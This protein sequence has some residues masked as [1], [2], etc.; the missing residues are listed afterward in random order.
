[1]SLKVI[2]EKLYPSYSKK[3]WKYI[4]EES[5][6]LFVQ[7]L[8]ICSLQYKPEDKSELINK[9]NKD[10][11]NIEDLFKQLVSTKEIDA[12]MEKLDSLIGG[13]VDSL[14]NTAVHIVK[15]KVSMG[16]QFNENCIVASADQKC[17]LRLRQDFS[18]EQK[19]AV[20]DAIN[21][22]SEIIKLAERKEM[23]KMFTR[24]VMAEFKILSYLS[25]FR[26]RYEK[27]KLV[28]AE[29]DKTKLQKLTFSLDEE[30]KLEI[31]E[32]IIGM[33][34]NIELYSD[35]CYGPEGLEKLKGKLHK[36]SYAQMHFSFL[37]DVL[38]W[39]KKNTASKA[40]GKVY[41][42]TIEQ[43]V[44]EGDLYILFVGSSDS[45]RTKS[46]VYVMK[47]ASF[48]ERKQWAQ[49]LSFLRDQ[50]QKDKKPLLFEKY[51]WVTRQV[52]GHSRDTGVRRAVHR[53]RARLQ[54]QKAR[55]HQEAAGGKK[56]DQIRPRKDQHRPERGHW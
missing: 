2:F 37:D 16:K 40:E 13:L 43:L 41:M 21:K 5:I 44:V 25:R 36:L 45:Q 46:S 11:T 28:L 29:R 23:T 17:I 52:L 38:L 22:Q 53:G 55:H 42:N 24:S 6:N 20:I 15:L 34:S 7:M 19:H 56:A 33:R 18:K 26:A 35:G 49:A 47:T 9:I 32:E 1:M 27:K 8:I 31:E 48:E 3:L 4:L 39:K 10:K 54:L 51:A 50:N 30:R 12:A 14:E